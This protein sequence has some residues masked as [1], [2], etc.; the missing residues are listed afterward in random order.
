[1][2]SIEP[3]NWVY[4]T[5]STGLETM[6]RILIPADLIGKEMFTGSPIDQL[7]Q[8]MSP[9][10]PW[11]T[12]GANSIVQYLEELL[13]EHKSLLESYN[14]DGIIIEYKLSEQ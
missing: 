2:E 4:A 12:R 10:A 6:V 3:S 13:P 5:G 8:A 1:V 11:T 9:L 14:N 7:I